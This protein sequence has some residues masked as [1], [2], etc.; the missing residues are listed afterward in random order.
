MG[1]RHLRNGLPQSSSIYLGS[2][3]TLW[4]KE[5]HPFAYILP[6]VCGGGQTATKKGELGG[7]T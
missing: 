6:Y 7:E 2:A 3:L 1:E 4:S 5:S